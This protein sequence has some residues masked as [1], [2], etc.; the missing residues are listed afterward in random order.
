MVKYPDY[1]FTDES[2]NYYN[3]SFVNSTRVNDK[4]IYVVQFEQKPEYID[5]M[6][7]GK[8]YI[9]ADKKILTSAIYS[10]NITDRNLAARMF[11]RKK[12]RN[13]N[14]WPTEVAYR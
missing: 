2:I 10:L 9:D 11:V 8:L 13:A 6:Y 3:F 7:K 4:L 5:P 14:V 12:P 1:I